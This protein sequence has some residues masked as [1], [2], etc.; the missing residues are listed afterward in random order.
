[1]LMVEVPVL[2]QEQPGVPDAG[3]VADL[4]EAKEEGA[5]AGAS[6]GSRAGTISLWIG[7]GFILNLIGVGLAL[8]VV[9]SPE[10]SALLGRSPEYVAGYVNAYKS[11]R[12]SAQFRWAAIGCGAAVL[13]VTAVALVTAAADGGGQTCNC[14]NPLQGPT[15]CANSW[16]DC[17]NSWSDCMSVA[18]NCLSF[19]TRLSSQDTRREVLA[20]NQLGLLPGSEPARR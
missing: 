5:A 6:A 4:A 3:Q 1:M 14:S 18:D 12:R 20:L 2:A 13:L 7:L 11:A 15:D 17:F 8:L 16:S 10:A 19:G 9:P